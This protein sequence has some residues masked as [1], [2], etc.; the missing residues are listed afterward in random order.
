VES[1]ASSHHL[2][3]IQF[4]LS[5]M[6]DPTFMQSTSNQTSG[7]R[8]P[9]SPPSTGQLSQAPPNV[10]TLIPV[11]EPGPSRRSE[12]SGISY[13]PSAYRPATADIHA[14]RGSEY[15]YDTSTKSSRFDRVS[16]A[17]T[18]TFTS[19]RLS[20]PMLTRGRIRGRRHEFRV[21]DESLWAGNPLNNFIPIR[22]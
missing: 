6:S 2:S 4:Y 12:V 16:A 3:P 15:N 8:K 10:S 7:S 9:D 14:S 5:E 18:G 1:T 13:P 17:S 11:Q 20:S 19:A 22:R 21:K